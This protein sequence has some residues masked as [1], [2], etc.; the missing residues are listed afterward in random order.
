MS[1]ARADLSNWLIHFVHAANPD[2]DIFVGDE[3]VPLPM[4]S[5]P[6]IVEKFESWQTRDF[7]EEHTRDPDAA[8]LSVLSQILA[9]GHLRA[10]WS[11]RSGKPTVYGARPAVCFTEMPLGALVE[12]ASARGDESNVAA[13]GIA[14][15]RNEAFRAGA[16]PVIYGLST[17]HKELES[18]WVLPRWLH[19]DC[20]IGKDELYRYVAL[21]LGPGWIDWTHEREWRW[22]DVNDSLDVPGLPLWLKD[23][24]EFSSVLIIV[25]E[26]T[27]AERLLDQLQT[28]HDAETDDYEIAHYD[29]ES[30]RRTRVLALD[31]VAVPLTST[32]RIEDLKLGSV[33]RP[34]AAKPGARLVSRL[35][36][37]LAEAEKAAAAAIQGKKYDGDFGFANIVNS[38]PRSA[39]AQALLQLGIAKADRRGY[40]LWGIL[41]CASSGVLAEDE[42]AAEAARDVLAKFFPGEKWW[43]WSRL[44]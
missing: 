22:C 24:P 27:E 16:R 32:V 3:A 6:L 20:G 15:R 31:D 2:N 26:H 28:M 41:R 12:Y 38:S 11:V 25:K 34:R 1:R 10:S 8:S 14:I 36:T 30:V 37:A 44:D 40:V 23:G 42:E 43:V 39:V 5:D 35:K 7:Y 9:D 33:A 18:D 21:Q 17:K 4:H 13:Y 29:R 19:P